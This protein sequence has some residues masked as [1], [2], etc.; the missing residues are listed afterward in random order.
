MFEFDAFS[1]DIPEIT[2]DSLKRMI[3]LKQC[4]LPKMN[5]LLNELEKYMLFVSKT[6]EKLTEDSE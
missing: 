5:I 6:Y 3:H 4:Y 2:L 1:S